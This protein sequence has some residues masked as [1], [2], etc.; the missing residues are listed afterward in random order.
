MYFNLFNDALYMV[1][2]ERIYIADAFALA[3]YGAWAWEE[4]RITIT[5][6]NHM[7]GL[8]MVALV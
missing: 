6:F 4:S 8:C 1:H 7:R 2:G 5:Q 3:D